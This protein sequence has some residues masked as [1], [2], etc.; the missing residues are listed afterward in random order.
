MN[1]FTNQAAKGDLLITRI[2]TLPENIVEVVD[3][4]EREHIVAHSETMHHHV[5]ACEDVD[6]FHAANGDDMDDFVSYLRVNKP[7]TLRHLRD[8]DTHPPIEFVPGIYRLNR[9]RE[10][11]IEGFRRA[12]D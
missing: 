7:T 4:K 2:D 6:Y 1:T 3:N 9:Q 12:Q 11:V 8:F 5:V 10:Y